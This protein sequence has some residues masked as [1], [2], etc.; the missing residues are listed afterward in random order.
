MARVGS[1]TSW[2]MRVHAQNDLPWGRIVGPK[3]QW[4]LPQWPLPLL[5]SEWV[6]AHLGP[7]PWRVTASSP[8]SG[9]SAG[10]LVVS[11]FSYFLPLRYSKLRGGL[12]LIEAFCPFDIRSRVGPP[13]VYSLDPPSRELARTA[14]PFS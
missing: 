6:T 8:R 9:R 10:A 14:T 5:E 2:L 11:F 4:P 7:N 3:K 12:P 13:C 1:L